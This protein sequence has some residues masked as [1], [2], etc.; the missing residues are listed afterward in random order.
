MR[1]F[2]HWLRQ[3]VRSAIVGGVQDALADLDAAAE[4]AAAEQNGI[5]TLQLT[6]GLPALVDDDNTAAVNGKGK[7]RA[8]V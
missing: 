7:R 1:G 8:G 4:H 6:L 2:F 5:P 3:Q